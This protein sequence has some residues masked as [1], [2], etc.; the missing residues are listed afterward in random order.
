MLFWKDVRLPP[1]AVITMLTRCGKEVTLTL[2][3]KSVKLKIVLI[4]KGH[5]ERTCRVICRHVLSLPGDIYSKRVRCDTSPSAILALKTLMRIW[6]EPLGDADGLVLYVLP[7]NE[8]ELSQL[9]EKAHD[10][11]TKNRKEVL[12]AIPRS[13]G[14]LRDAV[15]QLAYLHWIAENTPKLEGDAVARRELAGRR[16]EAERDVSDRLAAIFGG[17]SEESCRW[18]HQGLEISINSQR[19]RNEYLSKICDE[20]YDKTP[21]IRNELINRRKT[22]SAATTARRKLIQAMVENGNRKNLGII[23]YPAEMSIYRSLLWNTGIHSEVAGVWGFYPPKPDDKNNIKCTWKAIEDFLETC[24]GERQPVEDLYQRLMAPPFGV[25]QGPLP[26][27]LCAVM[28]YYKTEIALYENGSFIA[29]SS[30]P[31]LERLLKAPQQFELKRFRIVGPRAHLLA[32]FSDALNQ[33]A[34]TENL[35]LLTIVA[36]LMRFIS[37]LP[38]YTLT[39]QTLNAETKY[40]RAAVLNAREPDELL[41]NALPEALGFPALSSEVTDSKAF[42]D[43]SNTLRDA[44]S[45]LGRAYESLLNS[46]EKQ[47]KDVFGLKGNREA[48]RA[49]LVYRAKPLQE[50]AIEPHLKQFLTRICDEKLDFSNWLEAIGTNLVGKPPRSWIDQDTELF[51]SY[52]SELARKF[53]HFEVVSYEKREHTE[54][55]TGEPIRIGITRPNEP[56]QEQVVILPST[57]EEQA[58]KLEHAI[59]QI[60]DENDKDRNPEFRLA[61]LARISQ[62][63]MQEEK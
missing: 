5:S 48:S 36:P 43:F 8:D 13:V 56:E 16:I 62:K 14:F 60:F 7:E 41:F 11:H 63:L 28:E 6:R 37:R 4:Q 17:D 27:L 35:D 3:K 19:A 44:L 25:Q 9:I 2:R 33:T 61:V 54:S 42:S 30:M 40:L 58:D 21:I 57:A 46:I 1:I 39:T 32:H 26:I 18:Y 10:I 24:E 47:M 55:S 59:E 52:L 15:M 31:V 45:E 38:K 51:K 29:D 23:G 22:S 34:E 49:E 20:V 50:M 12:I 53:R